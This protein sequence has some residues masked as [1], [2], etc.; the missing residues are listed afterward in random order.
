M[1]SWTWLL[2]LDFG[3]RD[4]TAYVIIGW[5]E[6]SPVV[7][8]AESWKEAGKPPSEV[9][10]NVRELMKRYDFTRIVGDLGGMG[11]AFGEEMRR[12]YSIPIEPAEKTNKLGFVS[13]LN[14][15]FEREEL[16]I[17]RPT[18]EDLV[19]ELTELP[20]ADETHQKESDG[21]DNHLTDALLYAW[22]A[23][24]A[25]HEAPPPAPPTAQQALLDHEARLM[26]LAE[27]EERERQERDWWQA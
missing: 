3:I 13:L 8:V 5:R 10:E 25:Y 11:K 24:S 20:W 14:G 6:G 7:Y 1:G 22:R 19:K 18:N 9:A 2:G 26:E 16:L 15:A 21:F 12:R 17:V 4:A 27:E 23:A